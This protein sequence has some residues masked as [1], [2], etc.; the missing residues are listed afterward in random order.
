M[1][2]QTFGFTTALSYLMQGKKVRCPFGV[3]E[4]ENGRIVDEDGVDLCLLCESTEIL[5]D[6]WEL[7]DE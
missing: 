7:V 3:F 2:K 1:D 6:C 5:S 4:V